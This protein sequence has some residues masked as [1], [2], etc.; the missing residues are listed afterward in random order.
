MN[1]KTVILSTGNPIVDE[2]ST[3]SISGNVI[4]EVWYKTLVN[5]KNRTNPLAIL[6]LADIVYW[7]KPTENRDEVTNKVSYQKKFLDN[8]YLQRS[9]DQ[10]SK[11]FCISK[12]QARDAVI[13]LE[14]KGV[15]KRHFRTVQTLNGPLPNVMYIELIPAV[16]KKLTFPNN[17]E[18]GIQKKI[19]TPLENCSDLSKKKGTSPDKKTDTNTKITPEITTG[20]TSTIVVDLQSVFKGLN[21]ADKDL[22]AIAQAAHN[23]VARCKKA[24]QILDQQSKPI[25]NITGWLIKAIIEDYNSPIK[26][27]AHPKNT[28]NNFLGRDYNPNEIARSLVNRPIIP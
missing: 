18:G 6:I 7:Y 3:I 15:I 5:E 19:D 26:P 13:F 8:D 24:R 9:Y 14:Q 16:L 22:I 11:K 28:F 10:L 1:N 17:E 25:W 20:T 27:P 12:N 2:V 4:P 21:L 23:N